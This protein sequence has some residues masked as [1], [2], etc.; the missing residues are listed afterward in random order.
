MKKIGIA[1]IVGLLVVGIVGRIPQAH[2]QPVPQ[3]SEDVKAKN[4][5]Q[6]TPDYTQMQSAGLTGFG[7]F[8]GQASPQTSATPDWA[9][10]QSVGVTGFG[11]FAGVGYTFEAR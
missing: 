4:A 2:A 9:A 8:P 10:M 5:Q 6:P 3:T 1:A 7:T 11:D